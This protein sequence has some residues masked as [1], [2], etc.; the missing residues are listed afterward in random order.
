LR[1]QDV[2]IK[3]KINVIKNNS[4]GKF[5]PNIKYYTEARKKKQLN[6]INKSKFI[7]HKA[8]WMEEFFT[9]II[10]G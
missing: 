1:R 9:K 5:H 10:K 3:K 8:H 6:K 4:I 2:E 7:I